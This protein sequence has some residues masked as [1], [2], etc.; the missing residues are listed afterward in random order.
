MSQRLLW[1]RRRPHL[2]EPGGT[3]E[4]KGLGIIYISHY[5]EEMFRLGDMAYVLKDGAM[6]KKLM[7]K[8]TN[9]DELIKAHGGKGCIQLLS[10]RQL[11]IR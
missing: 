7:L 11:F 9:Q 8:E 2:Y 6:V 10:E 1:E 3:V 5:L 4:E